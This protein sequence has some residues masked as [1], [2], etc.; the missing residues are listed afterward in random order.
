MRC[1]SGRTLQAQPASPVTA[2][3]RYLRFA[4][5][6]ADYIAKMHTHLSLTSPNQARTV[7]NRGNPA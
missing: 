4:I 6:M 1:L 7:T 5:K 2:S 3:G